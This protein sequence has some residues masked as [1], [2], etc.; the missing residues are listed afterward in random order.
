M[1]AD[2]SGSGLLV[3]TSAGQILRLDPNNGAL[4]SVAGAP[5]GLSGDLM[6]MAPAPAGHL[7]VANRAGVVYNVNPQAGYAASIVWSNSGGALLD[8]RGLCAD[9]LG[10]PVVV[11]RVGAAVSKVRRV[12]GGQLDLLA[13]SARGLR[14]AVDPLTGEIFVS[15]QGAPGDTGGE[16]LRIEAPAGS[17]RSGH[18]QRNAYTT[19]PTGDFDG[20]LAFDDSGNLYIAEGDAGRVVATHRSSGAD[21]IVGANYGRPTALALAAGTPGT[22]GPPR[23]EPLRP[24]RLCHL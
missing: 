15:E 1:A 3:S 22:A 4:V 17:L 24:R 9:S 18:Y 8:V 16:I 20:A 10:R 12:N 13:F 7:L 19:Y 2:P 23:H 5:Q 6:A 11:D 21:T 14:P